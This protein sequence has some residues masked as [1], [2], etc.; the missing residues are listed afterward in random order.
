MLPDYLRAGLSVVFVGTS[1]STTSAERGHYYSNPTNKFWP[2]LGATELLGE[3]VLGPEDD[4]RIN[5]F[6]I[7]LT[8]IV[9]VRAESSDARLEE[10]DFDIAGFVA[11]VEQHRPLVIAFNGGMATKAVARH[12]GRTS[13]SGT[14]LTQLW[15]THWSSLAVNGTNVFFCTP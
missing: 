13:A 8:D 3:A 14:S 12:Q 1:V 6:G 9:K 11:K 4:A 7:G 15:P 10:E 2:L 5:D